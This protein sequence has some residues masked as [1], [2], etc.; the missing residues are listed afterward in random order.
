MMGKGKKGKGAR[1]RDDFFVGF[2]WGYGLW[3]GIM[4]LGVG[5]GVELNIGCNGDGFN[6]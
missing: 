6:E 1:G 5:V 4:V 3:I 2:L